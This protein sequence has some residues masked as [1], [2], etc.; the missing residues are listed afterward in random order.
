MLR[1]PTLS[2]FDMELPAEDAASALLDHVGDATRG[3]DHVHVSGVAGED[4]DAT[5]DPGSHQS[6]GPSGKCKVC[7]ECCFSPAAIPGT[8]PAVVAPDS[9]MRVSS[10][11]EPVLDSRPGD[12]PFCPARA[13]SA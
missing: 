6:H 12:G 10:F 1:G 13:T 4:H 7:G 8:P 3:H 9:P 11:V 2:Y 5:A